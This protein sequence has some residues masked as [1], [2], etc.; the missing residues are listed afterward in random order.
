M[1]E[2]YVGHRLKSLELPKVIIARK[3]TGQVEDAEINTVLSKIYLFT[4]L[5]PD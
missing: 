5:Y 2:D 3:E 4:R 1:I